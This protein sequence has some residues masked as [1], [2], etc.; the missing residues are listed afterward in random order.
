MWAVCTLGLIPVGALIGMST[1]PATRLI[2][3]ALAG[4]LVGL[5]LGLPLCGG[6]ALAARF[7]SGV[8]SRLFGAVMFG[9]LIL[10]GLAAVGFAGCMCI[11]ANTGPGNH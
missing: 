6:L 11:L 8:A 4:G 5:V 3:G 1:Q 9:L 10:V 7:H 2:D